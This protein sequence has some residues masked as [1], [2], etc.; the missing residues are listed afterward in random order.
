VLPAGQAL[1]RGVPAAAAP[2]C[3]RVAGGGG[4]S[5]KPRLRLRLR[6]RCT[7]SG[8]RAGATVSGARVRRVDFYVRGRRVA[9]DGRA[10]FTRVVQRPARTRHRVRIA[11]RAAVK[12]RPSLSAARTTRGCLARRGASFAG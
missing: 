11:A 8:L 10:P 3:G 6:L 9:R 4:G 7:P 12:G 5:K 1:A 2:G